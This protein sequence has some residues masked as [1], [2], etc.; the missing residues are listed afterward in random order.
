MGLFHTELF[1]SLVK[2]SEH[3]LVILSVICSN[4]SNIL[5]G[6]TDVFKRLKEM[7]TKSSPGSNPVDWREVNENLTKIPISVKKIAIYS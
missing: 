6:Y 5:N 3:L 1:H 4:D 7:S 2:N